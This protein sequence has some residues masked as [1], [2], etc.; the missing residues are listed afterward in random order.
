MDIT[1]LGLS[2]FKFR[3]KKAAVVV[4]PFDEKMVGFPLPKVKADIVTVSHDHADHNASGNVGGS[5]FV[6]DGPGEYEVKGIGI[7][8]LE[9]YHDDKQGQE[10]GRNTIF[11]FD[12]DGLSIL[13]LGDL[14]HELKSATTDELPDVDVLLIPVGGHFTIGPA[15]AAKIVQEI[16]PLIVIPMHYNTSQ[17][18]QE[19]FGQLSAVDAFISE[20]DTE[21]S[22]KHQKLT[23]HKNKLPA[24]MSVVVFE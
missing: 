22:E 18:N 13:H 9:T 6:I 17:L 4:D 3:G 5:P 2:S 10:R 20:L 14:G 19:V 1:Y 11:H 16:E 23:L 24:E 7:M 12:I 21:I 8:G 15:Q